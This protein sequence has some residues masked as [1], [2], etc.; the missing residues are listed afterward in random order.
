MRK[1][2]YKSQFHYKNH[3]CLDC[4]CEIMD[5]NTCGCKPVK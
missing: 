1:F 3:L 5:D 4:M 2:P